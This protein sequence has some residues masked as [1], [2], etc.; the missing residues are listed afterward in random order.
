MNKI[1]FLVFFLSANICSGSAGPGT[2]ACNSLR[3]FKDA[4]SAAV[5]G[6]Y[7]A[8]VDNADAVFWNPSRLAYIG[9][10]DLSASYLS[11]IENISFGQVSFAAGHGNMGVFG[12]G[13][14]YMDSGDI[15]GRDE[16]DKVTDNFEV[17][18]I[19]L[20]LGY[21]RKFYGAYSV[22][23]ALKFVRSEI[24]DASDSAFTCDLS[25]A[26]RYLF[27]GSAFMCGLSLLN[28]GG[29]IGPGEKASFPVTARLGIA[30][31]FFKERFILSGEMEYPRDIGPRFS[32]GTE[33]VVA[34]VLALRAGYRFSE[35]DIES[36][37]A[38][39]LGFGIIYDTSG[40]YNFDYAYSTQGEL[41]VMHRISMGVKF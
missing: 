2:T 3:I 37:G 32:V 6:A 20:S 34:G 18:D 14:S 29:E 27:Q 35:D 23:G 10:Y 26:Y 33:A 31:G 22:G 11:Y 15:E 21:G 41:G 1:F 8:F 13:F 16:E 36:I 12:L 25:G 7:T 28:L 5:G 38:F 30:E 39:S 24:K 40:Q 19:S 4:R 17:S 9:W